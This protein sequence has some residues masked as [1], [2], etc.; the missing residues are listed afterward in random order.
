[1]KPSELTAEFYPVKLK[2][3]SSGILGDYYSSA[4]LQF[5]TLGLRGNSERVTQL[6]EILPV[7]WTRHEIVEVYGQ[8]FV[9]TYIYEPSQQVISEFVEGKPLPEPVLKLKLLKADQIGSIEPFPELTRESYQK[10]LQSFT[11]ASEGALTIA[12]RTIALSNAKQ[13]AVGMQL[14]LIDYDEVFPW[15]QS[16]ASIRKILMPYL[17]NEELWKTQNTKGNAEFYFNMSLAGVRISDVKEPARTPVFYDPIPFPDSKIL[18]AFVDG[19]ARWLTQTE[20]S[21]LQPYLKLKLKRYGKPLPP[22]R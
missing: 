13:V 11:L 22:Q 20:W 2:E 18:V 19:A 12:K 14:Y 6:V 10:L 8:R 7:S 21:Q 1:M 15:V 4:Y 17:K 5:S 16:S 3:Q 9:V